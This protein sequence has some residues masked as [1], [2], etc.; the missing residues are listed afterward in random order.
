MEKFSTIASLYDHIE[1]NALD[2]NDHDIANLFKNLRDLKREENQLD[3]AQ[4]AQYEV[5]VFYFTLKNGN[6]DSL[7][8][9]TN[10]HGEI[11][12][13]PRVGNLTDKF[14]EYLVSRFDSTS[15]PKLKSR[16]GHILWFSPKKNGKYAQIAIE[17]YLEL[18]KLYEEKDLLNPQEHYGAEVLGSIKNAYYLSRNMN[19]GHLIKVTK[20]KIKSLIFHF[21]P[22]S[23]SSFRLKVDLIELMLEERR[24]FRKDDFIAIQHICIQMAEN[25]NNS[26]N[27]HAAIYLFELGEKIDRKLGADTYNWRLFIAE[28]YELWMKQTEKNALIATDFCQKALENY[29]LIKNKD[30]I[31]ELEKKYLQLKSSINLEPIEYS[32]DSKEYIEYCKQLARDIAK[33]DPEEIMGL[34][35]YDE[36]LLPTYKD[37][38]SEADKRSKENP[39]GNFFPPVILD[40]NGHAVQY[41]YGDEGTKIHNILDIYKIFLEIT[42]LHRINIIIL[43]AIKM[44]KL[45]AKIFINLLQNHSWFINPIT[46]DL[47]N[48][49]KLEYNW[50]SLIAPAIIEYFNQ[51][52]YFLASGNYPN[53]ILPLDSLTLKIEGI[54]R[55][56]CKSVDVITFTQRKDENGNIITL[57]K[58]INAL[59]HEQKIN[60]LLDDDDLILLKFLL[61]EKAGYNLRHNIA[62]SLMTF[63]HYNINFMHLLILA[64]LRLGKYL[65]VK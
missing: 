7:Y 1:V 42:Y 39:I 22:R 9:M 24:I 30:K 54:I 32:Y 62:H 52:D 61:V 14:C 48:G 5:D 12:E 31:E 64:L 29:R 2:Y 51:M 18:I 16:Y 46:K 36:A 38:S 19:D 26:E 8:S 58:D 65:T 15:N 49:R 53:L 3:E 55:E 45:S 56:L 60:E 37:I 11:I 20:S 63:E 4:I 23:V 17:C 21:N 59:L 47:P 40:D 35:M 27:L 13:Y 43:E 44:R 34:L 57:E 6:I 28:S 50:L 33:R 41:F 10:S 25:K